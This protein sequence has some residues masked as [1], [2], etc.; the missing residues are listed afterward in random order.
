MIKKILMYVVLILFSITTILPFMYMVATAFTPDSYIIPYPPILIP[1]AFYLGNF[2][3]ALSSNNFLKYFMNS[4][5]VSS[6]STLVAIIVS[7]MSAYAFARFEFRFKEKLFKLYLFSLMIPGLLNIVP[8][9]LFI[10]T[11]GLVDSYFGLI[12]LYVGAGI[13]YN[14]FFLRGFFQSIPREIEESAIIDG[15]S[16]FTIFTRIIM[17]LSKPALGTF[18]IFAFTGFWDEFSSALTIIKSVGKRTLPIAI[19]LFRQQHGTDWGLIFAATLI[20]LVPIII[21]FIVFQKRFIKG[22]FLSGSVKG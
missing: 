16:R 4:V 15:A 21:F 2:I 17:P 22:D 12:L 6:I 20:A 8:Q 19:Q 9:F 5:F 14:T 13:A 7:S 3:A 18:A 11:I 10:N 1:A